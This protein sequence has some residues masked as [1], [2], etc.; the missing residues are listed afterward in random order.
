MDAQQPAPR[1]RWEPAGFDFSPDGV[2]RRRSRD[3][4]RLRRAA[5]ARGDFSYLNAAVRAA[6]SRPGI[7]AAPASVNQSGAA[8]GGV[9]YVPALLVRFRNTATGGL[10]PASDYDA[11]LFGQTPP[12]GRPYT[13][14]TFYEEMSNTLLSVQGVVVGWIAL[15]S[16]DTYYS[17][18]CDGLCASG[19]R[20][21]INEAVRHAD[22]TV[23]F[24][25]FDND[26]P[27]GVPNSG[28]DD[29][30]VDLVWLIHPKVGSECGESN[31]IWAHR[32][33]Y[34]AMAGQ[35]LATTDQARSGSMIRIDNYSLQS[36]VGGSTACDGSQIMPVGTI[37]HET[38]HGLNLPDFYDTNGGD[39]DDSEGIGEWGLM[40][41]GNYARPLSPA[42]MESFS[43]LQLGWITVV[44]LTTGGTYSL[45]P[46]A[47]SDTAYLLRP[48]P[49]GAPNPRGEYFLLENR[50]ALEADTALIARRGGNPGLLIWHVDSTKYVN[51]TL[52]NNFVNTGSIHGLW[53]MQADGLNH[54]RSSLQGVRNRGDGGDPYPGTTGN[55]AFGFNTN[56]A[57][58][59][60]TPG[61]PFAGFV[62]D[63]IRQLVTNGAM[64]FRVRFGGLTVVR[65]SDTT[66]Q[67]RVRGTAFAVFRDVLDDGD[68]AT[69]AIDSFQ[70]ANGGR[71]EFTWQSWSDGGGRSHVITGSLAGATVTASVLARHKVTVAVAGSG[72]V[73][74]NP[75]LNI[76]AGEFVAAGSSVV[77]TAT[78]GSGQTFVGWSGDT[79][80]VGTSLT[81]GMRRPYTLTATFQA[82]LLVVD[83]VLSPAVGGAAY[84]D[85]IR[86]A[87]GT[88]SYAFAIESGSLPPGM[89]LSSGG[90]LSGVAQ[91]D[92]SYDFVVR[93][94]SGPQVLSLPL[95]VVV[96]APDLAVEAVVTQLLSGGAALTEAQRRYL[97]FS[98]NRNA[99]FDIG[100][101]IAWL[102]R[103]GALNA[104]TMNRI[105]RGAVR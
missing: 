42:H 33:Y 75:V 39:S 19:L 41:S 53:L 17:A 87:G 54:L 88:G 31:S 12:A 55:R 37:G 96:V 67:V 83:T 98:G 97:D 105:L 40:G 23:D 94:T 80:A 36:G 46:V 58:L 28:D 63:S 45:G 52:P 48:P 2:W 1:R 91:A 10:R 21:L 101:V 11:T 71:S 26:G 61:N 59:L 99:G 7:Y 15:D 18:N 95:R 8:V 72:A 86:L 13:V 51:N 9:L 79:A 77:L 4:A 20:P 32:W 56:P 27:D 24:T 102:D 76:G 69:V 47:T 70:T 100:D 103:T 73:A 49:G 85:T 92:S 81:L 93:V 22:S 89:T 6:R 50:Q 82:T 38:G 43:L 60:N 16:N 34:S 62:V 104:A 90:V 14:R 64:A 84:A 29:G 65:A 35:A 68:T 66:A 5:L 30:L 44:P 57:A 78:P 3:V 74:S 25:L